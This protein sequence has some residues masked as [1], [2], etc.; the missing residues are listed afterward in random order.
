MYAKKLMSSQLNLPP[1]W[2]KLS[3]MWEGTVN[4]WTLAWL[5]WQTASTNE[6]LPLST[7]SMFPGKL[8]ALVRHT[9]QWFGAMQSSTTTAA[10]H[11]IKYESSDQMKLSDTGNKQ[12]FRQNEW[13]N[14]LHYDGLLFVCP[15][16][17]HAHCQVTLTKKHTGQQISISPNSTDM[18]TCPQFI[19]AVHKTDRQTDRHPF[20]GPLSRTTRMSWYQKDKTNLDLLQQETVSGSGIS[21]AIC[22]SAPR[23]R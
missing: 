8:F 9:P 11:E 13:W 22:K 4:F 17:Q 18:Q 16:W 7:L 1:S 23:P 3:K 15:I 20:N 14:D 6:P 21:W 5:R 2:A 12:T 19:T 10:N